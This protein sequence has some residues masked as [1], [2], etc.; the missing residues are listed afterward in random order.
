MEEGRDNINTGDIVVLD[1]GEFMVVRTMVVYK[2]KGQTKSS[3]IVVKQ[4]N[5]GERRI[6]DG[7]EIIKVVKNKVL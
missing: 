1:S 7:E 4:E 2:N 3:W 5:G 6:G